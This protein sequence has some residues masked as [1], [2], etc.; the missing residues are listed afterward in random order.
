ML[1]AGAAVSG[2]G[3]SVTNAGLLIDVR[4]V[5]LNGVNL[6]AGQAKS[7]NVAPGDTVS[8][9]VFADVT[10]SNATKAQALQSLSGSFLSTGA[11]KGYMALSAAGQQKPFN[12]S[13][14]SIGQATDL[15]GDGDL[16]IGSNTPGDPAGFWAVRSAS[17]TGPRST[18][19]AG[20][21]VFGPFPPTAIPGGT[22]YTLV[23]NLRFVV[24]TAAG[25]VGQTLANFRNRVSNTG[26]LWVE[27]ATET[28]TDNGDTT[29]AFGYSGGTTFTDTSNVPSGPGV[30]IQIVPE[31][32]TLGLAGLA[33]LGM[34]IRR[35]K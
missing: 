9:R 19:D 2:L 10:G 31:P 22:E 18:D 7:V 12:A 29:T 15:D 1:L 16:D 27:N 33:G 24:S 26:G 8:L 17:L 13:G 21:T 25:N 6:T 35:R 30:L 32:T 20:A 4:A 11:L 34:L 28:S 5:K 14:A 3:V 23:D